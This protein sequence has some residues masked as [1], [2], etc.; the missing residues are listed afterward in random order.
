MSKK[1]PGY[2]LALRGEQ[3][4]TK[5]SM[6]SLGK[7]AIIAIFAIFAIIAVIF[8]SLLRPVYIIGTIPLGLIGVVV[9]FLLSAKALSFFAMI[10]IIGLAG[11]V[12]NA[13]IVLVDFINRLQDEGKDL[14]TAVI[15]AAQIRFRPILLTTTTTLAGL[16]PTAYGLGGSDHVLIPMTLALA[17]GLAAGTLAALV[18]IPVLLVITED[19]QNLFSKK[20]KKSTE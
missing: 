14:K 1:Y 16:L 12:V 4:N 3:E 19:I 18:V 5:K 20:F 7:A 8:N 15:E 10:G 13:S 11:V 9:G 17:W 6:V 2:R